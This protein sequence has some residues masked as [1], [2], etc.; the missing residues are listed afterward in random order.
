MDGQQS[1]SSH[2]LDDDLKALRAYHAGNRADPRVLAYFERAG[3]RDHPGGFN[4]SPDADKSSRSFPNVFRKEAEHSAL[5]D[6]LLIENSRCNVLDALAKAQELRL[7]VSR[8]ST[9]AT[10][11][12]VHRGREIAQGP[13][14][15]LTF[16]GRPAPAGVPRG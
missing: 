10:S 12:V 5:K 3:L 7:P 11:N 13:P 4:S 8:Q 1:R 6:R 2:V 9:F 14:F 16:S 15:S